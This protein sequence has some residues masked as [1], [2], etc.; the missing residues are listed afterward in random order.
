[1]VSINAKENLSEDLKKFVENPQLGT[2]CQNLIN[3]RK[4]QMELVQRAV[5]LE[6]KTKKML[7][8][9][10]EKKLSLKEKLENLQQEFFKEKTLLELKVKILEEEI[11]LKGCPGIKL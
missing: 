7:Q 10:P 11:V 3:K 1:M 6:D 8:K 9:V 2:R 5:S 4:S